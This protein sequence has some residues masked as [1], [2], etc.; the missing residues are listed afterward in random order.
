MAP[1]KWKTG[2]LE[3]M[4]QIPLLF[5]MGVGNAPRA[6]G[7]LSKMEKIHPEQPHWYLA[8]LGTATEHQGRGV[9]SALMKPVLDTCDDEGIP[10]YLESSKEANIPFYR[11]HGFEVKGEITIKDGPTL[12]PMWRDPQPSE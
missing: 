7:V 5:A 3:L 6:L 11:R 4:G 2:G 8:V 9:G 12:W 10:A 1:D